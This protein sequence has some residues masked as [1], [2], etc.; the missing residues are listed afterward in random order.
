MFIE[1]SEEDANFLAGGQTIDFRE[2]ERIRAACK[3]ALSTDQKWWREKIA[4]AEGRNIQYLKNDIWVNWINN[5]A[6]ETPNWRDYNWRIKPE[7]K[8]IK[9][10]L[11]V[12]I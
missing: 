10:V 11:M 8:K 6:H 3:S 2:N 5:S 12:K 1:L 9:S 7:P 4:F